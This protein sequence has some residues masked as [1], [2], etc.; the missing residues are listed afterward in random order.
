M[1][2]PIRSQRHR[3]S[4]VTRFKSPMM[5]SAMLLPKLT[6]CVP[7][8]RNVDFSARYTRHGHSHGGEHGHDEAHSIETASGDLILEVRRAFG[9]ERLLGRR[10]QGSVDERFE[11]PSATWHVT[12]WLTIRRAYRQ[13]TR[14][15]V[16]ARC[17]IQIGRKLTVAPAHRLSFDRVVVSD[18]VSGEMRV[19]SR[20][21]LTP[22]DYGAGVDAKRLV[23]PEEPVQS[24]QPPRGFNG[25]E[26]PRAPAR[27]RP[28]ARRAT[29]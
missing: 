3:R 20:T 19:V 2:F 7:T 29:H 17:P 15:A 4:Q 12:S 28:G 21:E 22:T 11:A 5:S 16:C 8:A 1:I 14:R 24:R 25:R 10:Q 13:S 23:N 6:A 18:L 27:R 26:L 9:C